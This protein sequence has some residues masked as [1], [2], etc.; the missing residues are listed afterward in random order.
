MRGRNLES[1][2]GSPGRILLDQEPADLR[3]ERERIPGLR[4]E[5]LP[6]PAF[7]LPYAVMGCGVEVSDAAIPG[8]AQRSS[9]RIVIYRLEKATQWAAAEAQL[10]H[11]SRAPVQAIRP[12]QTMARLSPDV[13]ASSPVACRLAAPMVARPMTVKSRPMIA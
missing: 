3:R 7:R 8:G 10:S 6:E 9:R 13:G 11:R 5:E 4:A 12:H 2:V 1:F